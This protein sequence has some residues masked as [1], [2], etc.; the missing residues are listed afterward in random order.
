MAVVP[1]KSR[2]KEVLC[3][4]TLYITQTLVDQINHIAQINDTNFNQVVIS[5]I[6]HCLAGP[7]QSPSTP[8]EP[9]SST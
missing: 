5:M 3:Y 2:R 1:H 8:V 4:R 7:E 6:E 9:A